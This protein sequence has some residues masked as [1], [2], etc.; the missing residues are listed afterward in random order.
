MSISEILL[1]T[2][3]ADA[4]LRETATLQLESASRENF[5]AYTVML[6]QEMANEASQADVRTAAALALKNTMTAREAPRRMELAE[7]WMSIEPDTRQEIKHTVLQTLAT[8]NSFVG[9]NVAQVVAAIASIEIPMGQWLELI[10]QLLTSISGGNNPTLKKAALKA[11]GYVCESI[12]PSILAVQSNQIL[13]A[14]AEGVNQQE[15]D[16]EVRLAAMNALYNSLEFIRT[17]FEDQNQRNYIMQLVCEAT[18]STDDR[19]KV[20]AFETM[21]RIM[22]LYYDRMGLYMEQALYSLTIMGMKSDNEQVALQAIEFWS[23][24][25]DEEIDLNEH[26][27][28]SQ[29]LGEDPQRVSM[30]FAKK[31]MPE[32]LPVLLAL[33]MNQDEDADDDDWNVS[34]ASATCLALLAQ[35]VGGDIVPEVIV[36]VER[37]I[38]NEDWHAREAAVM[39]FGSILDGPPPTSLGPL[40][41]QAFPLLIEMVKDPVLQVK[42]TAAWTLGRV[43]E[44]LIDS[45]QMDAHL[46]PLVAALV[47][48]LTDSPKIIANCSW[49]LMNL[50]QQLGDDVELKDSYLLSPFFEGITTALMQVSDRPDNENN[51]RTSVYEALSTIIAY[52]ARDCFT[53]ILAIAEGMLVRLETTFTLQDQI[54]NADDRAACSEIQSNVCSVLTSITRRLGKEIVPVSDRLMTILLRILQSNTNRT[55]IVAE[56]VFLC[57]S[58]LTAALEVDFNRY[59]ET[60]VPFL[61]TALQKHD[62]YQLCLIAIGLVGDLCRA[63]GE[64]VAPF[65]DT[66]MGLL[67]QMLYSANTHSDVKPAVLACLGDIALAIGGQFT[68]F[69]ANVMGAIQLACQYQID[70]A[71]YETIDYGNALRGSILEAYIGITQGLKAASATEGLAQYVPDIFRNMETIYH[72]HNRSPQILNGLV[73]LLGDLAETYPDGEL[74]PILTSA[75]VQQCLRDGR[76]SRFATKSTRNVARWAREMVKRACRGQ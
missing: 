2:L 58:A 24:V 40:V 65:C 59:T 70:P 71:N 7:K 60:F 19:V 64:Q 76:S 49:S 22:Q 50:G 43:C 28:E 36:F 48:G 41:N 51:A 74:T 13:T 35:C 62:E 34:M 3:A 14:V 20:A 18:Q 8:P 54:V 12:E 66:F 30:Q 47:A 15:T 69:L 39:A 37:N 53:T 46:H 10:Q 17:N 5:P 75:W 44:L 25:C 73:G 67:G 68:P 33:L 9:N 42:D 31:A 32:V 72:T 4:Q 26:A 6:C 16:P 61:C 45:I 56:D 29:E 55:S 57:I 52:A 1:N 63:L 27:I 23:T 21:V 11:I 38:R